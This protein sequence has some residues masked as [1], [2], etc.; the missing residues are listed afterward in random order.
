MTYSDSDYDMVNSECNYPQERKGDR[1]SIWFSLATCQSS[2]IFCRL[3]KAPHHFVW[4]AEAPG[5]P[6]P[7][8]VSET[9]PLPAEELFREMPQR[10]SGIAQGRFIGCAD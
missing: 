4:F 2:H 1:G 8:V 10:K 6:V 9:A 5:S 7:F 3:R